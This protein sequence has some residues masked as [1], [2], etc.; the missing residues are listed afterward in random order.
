[1]QF[2]TA[3]FNTILENSSTK[4]FL[5]I[6]TDNAEIGGFVPFLDLPEGFSPAAGAAQG[7]HFLALRRV[8]PNGQA[9]R[10]ATMSP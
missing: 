2:L 4:R 1:M 9:Q 5:R 10:Q 3:R 6:D 7:R 8:P